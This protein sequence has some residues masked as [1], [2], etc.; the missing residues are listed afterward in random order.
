MPK[1][2]GGVKRDSKTFRIAPAL[3]KRLAHLAVDE[4][5]RVSDLVQEAIEQFLDNR[6]THD[7]KNS[8]EPEAQVN[9]LDQ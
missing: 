1:S 9:S 8:K 5:K 7:Q 2:R 3:F 6:Q 4:D